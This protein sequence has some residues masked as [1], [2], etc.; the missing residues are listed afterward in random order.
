[1]KFIKLDSG[2]NQLYALFQYGFIELS[3]QMIFC[4]FAA[5]LQTEPSLFG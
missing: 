3:Y 2:I 5:H 4:N 1:M